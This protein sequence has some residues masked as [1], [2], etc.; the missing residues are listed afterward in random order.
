MEPDTHEEPNDVLGACA[1]DG[2]SFYGAATFDPPLPPAIGGKGYPVFLI[3]V[4]G[5]TFRFSSLAELRVCIMTLAQ[6]HLPTTIRLS[7]EPGG[8]GPN[9]HWLSRLPRETKSWHYRE[10]AVA[11]MQ[12]AFADFEKVH[13]DD[14]SNNDTSTACST[15]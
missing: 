6:K 8:T 11:Y 13:V 7:Q 3:E 9:G 2:K 4:D 10:R 12:K 15:P 5:F 1:C 14:S